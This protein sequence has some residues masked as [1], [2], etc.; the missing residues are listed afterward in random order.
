MSLFLSF[1]L[2]FVRKEVKKKDAEEN[3]KSTGKRVQR[4]ANG[5]KQ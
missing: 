5:R 2:V 4:N 1:F 3:N